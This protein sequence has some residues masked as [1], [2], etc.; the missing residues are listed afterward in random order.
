[1]QP[2]CVSLSITIYAAAL[3]GLIQ[4]QVAYVISRLYGMWMIFV[5]TATLRDGT[6]LVHKMLI[7]LT[8]D[9]IPMAEATAQHVSA[10]HL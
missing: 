8:T 10:T 2:I 4:I 1:M 9:G 5:T 3:I 7:L 6:P